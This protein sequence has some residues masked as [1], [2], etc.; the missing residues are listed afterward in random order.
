VKIVL[1]EPVENLGERGDVVKVAA[2][3]AR[4]YLLPKRLAQLATA[5][6]LSTLEHRRRTWA[7][8]ETR[9]T[10][11]AQA[12]AA[13][14]AAVELKVTRKAGESGTLYGSVTSSEIAALLAEQGIEVNR[15]KIRLESPLKA[16]GVYE[17]PIK[18]HRTVPASIKVEVAAEAGRRLDVAPLEND[19]DPELEDDDE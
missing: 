3:Y 17:I 18:T 5:G 7:V 6:N 4:N 10:A 11:E 14:L 8:R 15:R 1:C 9:E 19:L 12:V 16:I 2:G 13:R